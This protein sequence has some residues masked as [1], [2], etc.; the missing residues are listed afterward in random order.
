MNIK[1]IIILCVSL[2]TATVTQAQNTFKREIAFGANAGVNFSSV[3]FVPKVQ[4]KQLLGF[5]GGGVIRWLSEK[6]LGLQA[7][8]NLS[9]QGWSEDFPDYPDMNY[10]YTR[11][12]NY[13]DIPFLTHIY[14]GEKKVRFFINLGPKIGYAISES[15]SENL[16]GAKPNKM[17]DQHDMPVEY[18][19]D[20]GLCGGPGLEFRTGV[21]YFQLEGRYTYALGGIYGSSK[22]DAFAKSAKQVLSVRVAYLI[23]IH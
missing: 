18:K 22:E 23:P 11:T 17:N 19:F 16:N 20:W 10:A 8:V 14:F 6:H 1:T 7:E 3:S 9:Q 12:I 2:V 21:G 4:Q 5:N 15:T 13:I